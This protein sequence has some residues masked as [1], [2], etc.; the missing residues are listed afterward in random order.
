M[1]ACQLF[2]NGQIIPASTLDSAT[3]FQGGS[4]SQFEA[5]S[6]DCVRPVG[7]SLL[8]GKSVVGAS[9]SRRDGREFAEIFQSNSRNGH[10]VQEASDVLLPEE[11]VD[12][13]ANEEKL[14]WR[15]V[16]TRVCDSVLQRAG[17]VRRPIYIY[18]GPKSHDT[19]VLFKPISIRFWIKMVYSK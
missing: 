3:I 1:T 4:A 17:K 13:S 18:R 10:D 19:P 7:E 9:E 16:Q 12:T 15:S 6:E 14:E 8:E 2:A 5:V 11:R